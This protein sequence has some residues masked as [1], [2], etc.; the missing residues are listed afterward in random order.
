MKVRRR[1]FL[2]WAAGAA[3]LPVV[4]RVAS[5]QQTY[6]S[7]PVRIIV[8]FPAGGQGDIVVRLIGQRLAERLGQPFVVENRTGAAGNIGTEAVV[9]SA[10]DG[11]TLLFISTPSTINASLYDNLSFHFIRDIAPVASMSRGVGV[12]VVTPNFPAKTLPEFIN[13][14][15]ANP[16]KIGMASGGYGSLPHLYGE[17]FDMMGSVDL[18]HVPYRGTP[19]AMPDLMSGQVQV[20][21]DMVTNSMESIKAGKLRALGVT[22]TTRMDVLPDVPAIAEFLP[23]YEANGWQ[24]IGAPRDTPVQILD[25]LNKE[26][27]AALADPKINTRLVDLGLV[28]APMSR[29]AFGKFIADETEKWA[30][31]IKFAG[32]KPQ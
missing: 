22:S 5:G 30:R 14:A 23:G 32:I 20:M 29:A 26:I 8:P 13:Y 28:P 2:H 15:K 11:Y 21:F 9:R 6:P 18:A 16:G 3:L 7:R 4:S 27:N 10:P 19:L 25:L 17:L 31:V 12:M 1:Q 24:G